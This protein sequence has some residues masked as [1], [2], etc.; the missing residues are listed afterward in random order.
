MIDPP[1]PND[2]SG[3]D[4][5]NAYDRLDTPSFAPPVPPEGP[6]LPP[7][8]IVDGKYLIASVIGEG[9]MGVVYAAEHTFLKKMVA[10]KLLRPDVAAQPEAA[11]R[12]AC[13]L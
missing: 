4:D 3:H 13:Q 9:G 6:K 11:A 1:G 7:G 8:S 2:P 12:S 10:L 5:P